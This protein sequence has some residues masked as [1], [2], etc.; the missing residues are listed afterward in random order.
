MTDNEEPRVRR[1]VQPIHRFSSP[2]WKNTDSRQWCTDIW[3][4]ARCFMP[5]DGYKNKDSAENTDFKGLINV[6]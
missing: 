4:L 3:Q 6:D 5:S 1:H 2:S